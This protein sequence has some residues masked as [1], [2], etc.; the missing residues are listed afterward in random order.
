MMKERRLDIGN[1]VLVI[2]CSQLIETVLPNYQA[3]QETVQLNSQYR[4]RNAQ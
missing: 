4:T 1:S 3:V 2:E